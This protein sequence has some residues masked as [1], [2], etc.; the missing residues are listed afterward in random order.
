MLVQF[1]DVL[2]NELG[3]CSCIYSGNPCLTGCRP[4]I[5]PFRRPPIHFRSKI[6]AGLERSVKRGMLERVD[7]AA[8]AFLT[9]NVVEKF[10]SVEISSH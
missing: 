9:V 10:A 1:P 3:C 6:E 5:Y 4:K 7:A 2:K 8:C